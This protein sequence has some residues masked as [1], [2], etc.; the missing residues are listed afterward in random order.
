MLPHTTQMLE[1]I[2]TRAMPIG[3]V[4][5]LTEQERAELLAWIESGAQR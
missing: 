2:R 1:Q 5:G 3:N 4:T